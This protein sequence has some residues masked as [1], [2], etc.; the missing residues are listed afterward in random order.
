[1]IHVLQTNP[2]LMLYSR[3]GY[4][5]IWKKVLFNQIDTFQEKLA[6]KFYPPPF[7]YGKW[8]WDG[9]LPMAISE[10]LFKAFTKFD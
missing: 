3:C 9:V 5:I 10:L 1:M 4:C 8:R 6:K 2:K 7:S